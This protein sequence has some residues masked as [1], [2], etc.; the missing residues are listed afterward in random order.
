MHPGRFPWLLLVHELEGMRQE[1]NPPQ[2][3]VSLVTPEPFW[4]CFGPDLGPEHSLC[5]RDVHCSQKTGSL[6]DK[7]W[8][9]AFSSFPAISVC[10]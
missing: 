4:L 7:G 10:P 2:D 3:F 9:L 5:H 8:H 6:W 1:P